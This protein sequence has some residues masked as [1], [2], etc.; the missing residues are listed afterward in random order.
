MI[1]KNESHII[2]ETLNSVKNHIDYWVICDTGSTDNTK[3]LIQSF[4]DKE[5]LK[6]ELHSAEWR[7]FGYN[8][9][10]V[11]EF[12]Y[13]KADYL[14][15]ID[16]DDILVGQ[17]NLGKLNLDSYSLRYGG[18]FIYWR[19]QIFKGDL[20][21]VYKGVLHEFPYCISKENSTHG[22][23]EGNYYVDSRRLGTRNLIDPK[24]KYLNDAKVL[25]DALEDE[26]DAH[27]AVRYMFYLAQSYKDA[28]EY[29]KAMEWYQKRAA[30]GGWEEE[31][32]YSKY[33]IMCCQIRMGYKFE[34]WL[35]TGLDAF[36][37]RPARLEALYEIILYCRMT[38]QYKLGYQL[39]KGQEHTELSKDILFVATLVYEWK[40]L[41]E[42]SICA[43]WAG[44][45]V[46]S[47]RIIK[48]I[49][50]EKNTR[51]AIMTGLCRIWGFVI[52][53]IFNNSPVSHE[54]E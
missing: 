36:A 52:R 20:Q 12:A 35:Y 27:L 6:G 18:D 33:M 29:Q 22:S 3:E 38:E 21:W 48:K 1:V 14:W 13:K 5:G 47:S 15:V 26:T 16:A 54:Q 37:Y 42:L 41:D 46:M 30:A 8:R 19:N 25:E 31:V 23:I 24:T 40:F 51:P 10:L 11:F 4:F 17:L 7:D 39:G 49:L 32:Y 43:Y 53:G 45:L 28:Q 9:T 2:L 50:I 34:H 44:D